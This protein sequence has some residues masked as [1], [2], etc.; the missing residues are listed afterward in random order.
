M[1]RRKTI[2]EIKKEFREIH[3]NK[4]DYSLIDE[5]IYVNSNTRLPIICHA[6]NENN[7]EH[8]IFYQDR[9]HHLRGC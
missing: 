2:E 9:S 5:N 7:I 8:G 3:G 4:Y 1:S 6:I